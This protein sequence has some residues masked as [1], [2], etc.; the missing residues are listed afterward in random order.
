MLNSEF[1]PQR[2][3]SRT[4]SKAYIER[5]MRATKQAGAVEIELAAPTDSYSNRK[6]FVVLRDGQRVDADELPAPTGEVTK[7]VVNPRFI[8]I[9]EAVERCGLTTDQFKSLVKEKVFPPPVS[10]NL[11]D[12]KAL[13]AR[14]DFLKLKNDSVDPGHVYFMELGDFIKIGWS[15]WPPLRRKDLQSSGP[16]DIVLLG[17]FPGTLE[18]EASLHAVFE[19]LGH[20]NEWFRKS[21]ALL[22]YIAW[23]KVAWRG[24]P[25]L[26]R[27]DLDNVVKLARR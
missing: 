3:M 8:P 23:L 20:R 26:F 2:D 5:A 10:K 25:R 14:L 9:N 12:R 16:Y 17:A 6:I 7:K 15:R 27:G 4:T 19:H 24:D 18:N 11:W 13:Y 22:A 1:P 21:P